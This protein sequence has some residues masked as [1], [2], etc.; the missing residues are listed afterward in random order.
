MNVVCVN[1]ERPIKIKKQ[2]IEELNIKPCKCGFDPRVDILK[3]KDKIGIFTDRKISIYP[4]IIK[5]KYETR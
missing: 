2:P 5:E 4:F 1:C 3:Y